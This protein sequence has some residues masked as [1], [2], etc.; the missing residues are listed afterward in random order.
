MDQ[1]GRG[2]YNWLNIQLKLTSHSRWPE[3][4]RG[5]FNFELT[6][7]HRLIDKK[8]TIKD[9]VW[10]NTDLA[11]LILDLDLKYFWIFI[12]AHQHDFFLV[13]TSSRG[14]RRTLNWSLHNYFLFE[15]LVWKMSNWIFQFSPEGK[16]RWFSVTNVSISKAAGELT[17]HHM[18][19]KKNL[20]KVYF[21]AQWNCRKNMSHS[22]WEE[23]PK[24]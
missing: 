15:K 12:A 13:P 9:Q 4:N 2:N 16:F 18:K 7:P 24:K 20:S 5:I 3:M 19:T 22:S 17:E 1:P 6:G 21:S 23:V 11:L 14:W 8:W 10:T